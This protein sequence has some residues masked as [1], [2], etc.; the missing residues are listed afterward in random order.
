M[1]S[2]ISW[3][4]G[5]K[6]QMCIRDRCMVPEIEAYGGQLWCALEVRTIGTL[7]EAEQEELK[8]DCLLYTSRCV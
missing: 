4:G 1:N 8:R 3:I 5:K 6:A 2:I 7:T